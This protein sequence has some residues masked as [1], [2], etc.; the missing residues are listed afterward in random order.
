[1][2]TPLLKITYKYK[3]QVKHVY[4]KDESKNET[5]SIK[6]RPAKHI[7]DNA[8][9]LGLLNKDMRVIE[10]TSGNMGI[11]I[12]EAL[13]PYGNKLTIYMPYFMSQERKDILRSYGADLVL[14]S[15]FAEAFDKAEKDTNSFYIK[16]FENLFNAQSYQSLIDEIN[17]YLKDIPC[18]VSGVGT[19]GTINGIGHILKEKYG[20]KVIAIDPKESMLLMTG[21]NHG[22]H[23]IEGLSDGFIPSL[24][25]KDIVDDIILISS[26]DAIRMAQKINDYLG[27]GVGISSGAYFLGA[28]LSEVD[29]TFTVFPDNV[30]RYYSTSLF[31]KTIKGEVSEEV[32]LLKC[33]IIA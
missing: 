6:I 7:I 2:K 23:Q 15:S 13:K 24:Y 30:N 22:E 26:I 5:G 17:P 32:E 31:D 8:Y 1:M 33:E 10:V 16:Q 19:G 28:V 4:V 27:V 29:N 21:T 20:T 9:K 14:T 25:P 11:G 12:A 3:N 18:F